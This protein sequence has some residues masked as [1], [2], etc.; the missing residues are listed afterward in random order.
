MSCNR[1][2]RNYK[3]NVLSQNSYMT[4]E[5]LV[6]STLMIFCRGYVVSLVSNCAVSTGLCDQKAL[7]ASFILRTIYNN[8]RAIR[9]SHSVLTYLIGKKLWNSAN[10][11]DRIMSRPI[12]NGNISLYPPGKCSICSIIT[13]HST[14]N[15][16]H[17]TSPKSE[18]IN[19]PNITAHH[20]APLCSIKLH[21]LYITPKIIVKIAHCT[22]STQAQ[23]CSLIVYR[24]ST[25]PHKGITMCA[26]KI[27]VNTSRRAISDNGNATINVI[28]SEKKMAL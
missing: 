24:Q 17:R 27:F 11:V 14:T 3:R 10:E 2:R 6:G 12:Y 1:S 15:R 28:R 21:A 18:I 9:S 16:L 26:G 20:H 19:D 8:P 7:V 5:N 22:V 4:K 23:S 25:I 13:I